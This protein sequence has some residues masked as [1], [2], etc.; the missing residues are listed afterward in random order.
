VFSKYVGESEE[1]VRKLFADA[2]TDEENLSEESP[3]H[4]IIFDEFDA[5][6]K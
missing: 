4:I 3:L 2:R 1:N 5:L 6:C